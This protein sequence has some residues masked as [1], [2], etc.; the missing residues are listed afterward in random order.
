MSLSELSDKED[1]GEVLEIIR[2]LMPVHG[3]MIKKWYLAPH[4]HKKPHR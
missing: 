4:F 2:A 3:I 1:H